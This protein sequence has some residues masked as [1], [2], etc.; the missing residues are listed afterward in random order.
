[1]ELYQHIYNVCAAATG[2]SLLV[3]FSGLAALL[4]KRYFLPDFS[5]D[6]PIRSRLSGHSR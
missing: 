1:M 4:F 5:Q 3:L 6:G 2:L